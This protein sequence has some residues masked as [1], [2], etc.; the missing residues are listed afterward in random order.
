MLGPTKPI[1]IQQLNYAW[2]F[3]T[4]TQFE[5]AA[6]FLPALALL[7]GE[8]SGIELATTGEK[9]MI[10]IITKPSTSIIFR[11]KFVVLPP[12]P[13]L[14]VPAYFRFLELDSPSPLHTPPPCLA[15]C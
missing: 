14:W 13:S 6:A 2:A 5:E 12:S 9:T 8:I 1:L 10:E 11:Y 4:S 15:A 7:D 3:M